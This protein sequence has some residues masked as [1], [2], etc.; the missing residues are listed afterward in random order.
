MKTLW[1]LQ[2]G[3]EILNFKFSNF[4][5]TSQ[6]YLLTLKRVLPD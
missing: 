2:A 5:T 1:R 4:D 3:G 6:K